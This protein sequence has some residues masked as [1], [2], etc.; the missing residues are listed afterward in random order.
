M[1]YVGSRLVINKQQKEQTMAHGKSLTPKVGSSKRKVIPSGM[2][3]PLVK[4]PSRHD[5]HRLGLENK[6]PSK[7]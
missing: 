3:N 5:K 7:R 2:Y 6:S 1:P 4:S